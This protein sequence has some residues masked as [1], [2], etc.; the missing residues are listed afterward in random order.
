MFPRSRNTRCP[1]TRVAGS[2]T[3]TG[4]GLRTPHIREVL[5]THPDVPWFEILADNHT[6]TGG[7]TAAELTAIREC[8]PITF[9]CV[10]LSL[11]SCDA[12]DTPYLDRLKA[13]RDRY[14]PAWI[15]DHLSFSSLD[16]T[17]YHDLLPLPYTEEAV[18]HVA[19]RINR[20]QEYLGERILIENVSSYM[21]YSHS[22]LSE[23]E[24]LSAVSGTADCDILLD[25]NNIYV[26]EY[27][28]GLS[29]INYLDT[30]PLQRVQEIHLGGYE[31]K[32]SF[33][34]DAHNHTVSEPVWELYRECIRRIPGT[35]VLIEWDNDLPDFSVLLQEARQAER[36]AAESPVTRSGRN[37]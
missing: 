31:D 11:G 33:L 36:L 1:D 17:C 37:R 22:M 26:N 35:P 18:S 19:G 29:G 30:I 28:H 6:S 3:G 25:I 21:T 16:G 8:Y 27:N 14:Q 2:I 9:H 7:R 5:D 23:A 13:M 20:V 34:L 12:L 15:S 32:G 24:F 4:I 10:G